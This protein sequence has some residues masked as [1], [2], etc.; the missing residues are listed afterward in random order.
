MFQYFPSGDSAIIVKVGGDISVG[1]NRIVRQLLARTEMEKIS[2]ITDFIPSY[3]ELMICYDP[4]IIGFRRL[5]E[6]IQTFESDV[7]S[8]V[9]PPFSSILVPVVY[10]GTYGPDLA[11][12]AAYNRLSEEDVI[13]IHSSATY[14]VYMLGFTP[15][16]CYLGGIDERI[17]MPRKQSPRL[18]IP[19]GAVGIA[20]RQ[21]GIYPIE[22]PGGWQLIGQTPLKLFDINR[23][24]EF[25]FTIGDNL[26]F[27]AIS[28]SEYNTIQSEIENEAYKIK[29]Q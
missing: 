25:L 4:A 20:D 22:S 6:V 23:K 29:T 16:F 12:V 26:R 1:T 9:L 15:G 7:D 3:N 11:D 18:K 2:G 13:K 27:E 28:E 5:I 21:T 24:P 8:I 19:E 10:G 14:L 17:A